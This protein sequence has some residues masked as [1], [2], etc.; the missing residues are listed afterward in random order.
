MNPGGYAKEYIQKV[1]PGNPIIL[2]LT[3]EKAK[4]MSQEDLKMEN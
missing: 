1:T 3:E 2:Y 4:T